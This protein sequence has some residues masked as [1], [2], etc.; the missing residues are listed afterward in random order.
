M[1]TS[2]KSKYKE[3]FD[4]LMANGNV[5]L[6]ISCFLK[7]PSS[8]SED[9]NT[10]TTSTCKGSHRSTR[11]LFGAVVLG[12]R[13]QRLIL[14][15]LQ[16]A[17]TRPFISM[18]DLVSCRTHCQIAHALCFGWCCRLKWLKYA[19]YVHVRVKARQS[20]ESCVLAHER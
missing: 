5:L 18:P 15:R 9:C 14:C 20:S 17:S 4:D 10:V 2:N 19:L 8:S 13:P 16:Q 12:Y 1:H 3:E 6:M 11:L 7:G